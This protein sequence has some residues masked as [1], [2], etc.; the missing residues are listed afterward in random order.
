M[1]VDFAS[2]RVENF[3]GQPDVAILDRYH[4]HR[5]SER[6]TQSMDQQVINAVFENGT[7]RPLE[8][9]LVS[10]REGEQLRLRIE[11]NREPTSLELACQVYDGLS[12][13]EIEQIERIALDRSK[14]F[15]AKDID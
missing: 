6:G 4:A 8:P 9:L 11:E 7:F 14:F 10:V 13:L 2:Q 5:F 1:K 15:L 12:P 3:T